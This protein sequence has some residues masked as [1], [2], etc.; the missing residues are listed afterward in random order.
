MRPEPTMVQRVAQR[1]YALIFL[2]D[3]D[4][5]EVSSGLLMFGWGLQL[6]LPWSTFTSAIG[7]QAMSALAPEAAWGGLLLWVGFTQV[8][9]YLLNH[10]RVRIASS[11]GAVM[12]WAFLGV[13][14]G[15]SNPQGTGI[16]VYPFLA[17]TTAWVFWRNVVRGPSGE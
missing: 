10:W 5:V 8:G 17:A 6:M 11:L 7:Y 15:L 16:V 1:A 2:R 13:L 9:S 4:F 14:F 3:A 12:L